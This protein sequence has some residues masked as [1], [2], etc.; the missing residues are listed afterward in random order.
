VTDNIPK[1]L[2]DLM[3]SCWDH[4]PHRRPTFEQILGN[5]APD[6]FVYSAAE[7]LGGLKQTDTKNKITD[8]WANLSV[9]IGADLLSVPWDSFRRQFLQLMHENSTRG[10]DALMALLNVEENKQR[11]TWESFD[12]FLSVFGPAEPTMLSEITKLVRED[13]FWGDISSNDAA[14]V[15]QSQKPGAFLVRFSQNN[16][17]L[18][19]LSHKVK[20]KNQPHQI[21]HKR[22]T[23]VNDFKQLKD[24]V[25]REKKKQSVNF[26]TSLPTC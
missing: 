11:V 17:K 20:V 16:T 15:L 6:C 2:V 1:T 5:H 12:Q 22:L 18:F 23:S 4:D 13:W 19:T 8:M 14:R 7:A 24:V 10:P 21:V 25:K 26:S 9:S 3:N